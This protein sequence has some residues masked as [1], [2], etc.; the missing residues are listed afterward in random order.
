MNCPHC[1]NSDVRH[2]LSWHWSDWFHRAL[3]QN[4]YRCRKC[5]LRFFLPRARRTIANLNEKSERNEKSSKRLE[6]LRRK[7]LI[8]RLITIAVF[9]VMFSVF[10][11]FL[12]HI[13]K[14]H[15]ASTQNSDSS[16]Q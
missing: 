6:F 14:D 15:P 4:A 7:R 2:S 8:R 1:G 5:Q 11:L 10:G 16:D 13:S 9:V 12:L 3:G